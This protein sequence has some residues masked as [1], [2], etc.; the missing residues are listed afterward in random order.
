MRLERIGLALRPGVFSAQ[1]IKE[2]AVALELSDRVS[3][4]FVP[5]I[6]TGYE[7]LEIASSILALTKR[8]HSGSGVIRL[9]EHDPQLLTRR[10]QTLQALSSNRLI[11]GVGTGSPGPQPGRTVGAILQRLDELKKAFGGFPQGVKPPQIYVAALKLGMAKRAAIKADGL[12]L[13]FCSPQHAS[14][15][16]EAAR[17]ARV[18]GIDFACYLK[19]FYSSQGPESAQ[20]LM[21]QEFLNYDSAPQYHEMF[22]Q[23]GTAKAISTFKENEEWKSGP[24]DV[25][26]ELLRVSLANP[27]SD[28]LVQYMKAFRQAG[29]TLPVVY[30]YFPSGEGAMFKLETV[31]RIVKSL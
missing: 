30:P 4:I 26:K 1:E 13:N 29:V 17:V 8:V 28:E 10:V 7:S 15:L 14:K 5:D 6:R 3:R 12:L 16:V 9:L 21:L 20:R 23:D 18:E 22:V 24:V 11:L 2:T 31:N 19:I 25:P 27:E